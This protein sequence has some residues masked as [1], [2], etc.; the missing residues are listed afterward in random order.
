MKKSGLRQALGPGLLYAGAA[1]GVSH[2]VQSTRA[3]AM[4]GFS[5]LLFVVLVNLVKCPFFA[6][7]ARYTA[8]SKKNLLEAYHDL[9]R[10]YLIGFLVLTLLTMLPIATAIL[11][12]TGGI[13]QQTLFP[14]TPSWLIS[15]S[16][17]SLAALVLIIGKFQWFD[18]SMKMIMLLLSVATV[19]ALIMAFPPRVSS[20]T[21]LVDASFDW[22]KGWLFLIAL[23]GW[24]PTPIDASVW[25]SMWIQEKMKS[26]QA[27]K[28]NAIKFDFNL[29]YGLT[30][31]LAVCFLLLGALILFGKNEIDA[32]GSA[33]FTANFLEMYVATLGNWAY[34][35]VVLSVLA[36]MFSTL[37][38]ILDAYPR[39]VLQSYYLLHANSTAKP[40]SQRTYALSIGGF[41]LASFFLLQTSQKSMLVWVDFSTSLSFLSAPVFAWW[42]YK[43]IHQHPLTTGKFF[44]RWTQIGL[45]LL[46][47]FALVY[48]IS[49]FW[50]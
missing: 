42:N 9:G 13:L 10:R 31:F 25:Q 22:D 50:L 23:A 15:L 2:V 36:T 34:P 47:L 20:L 41:A 21:S 37:I 4:Y 12:V 14:S 1:V 28:L 26:N 48:L 49:L 24:M 38:T 7:G 19:G 46:I 35:L 43:L 29:G 45:F 32:A 8:V 33:A 16:S 40:P 44:L 3:G 18:K 27:L 17:I 5:L 6:I 11:T 30:T 39:V